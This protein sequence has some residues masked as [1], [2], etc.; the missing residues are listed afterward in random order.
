MYPVTFLLESDLLGKGTEV[1]YI[2]IPEGIS[3]SSSGFVFDFSANFDFS[4]LDK[5]NE[6]E[7]SLYPTIAIES[8]DEFGMVTIGFSDD[9]IVIDDLDEL[10]EKELLLD[11]ELK[12]NLELIVPIV[13]TQVAAQVAF[14]WTAVSFTERQLKIQLFFE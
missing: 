12:L 2:V 13:E 9:L 14:T 1:I 7:L 5:N 4:Q 3:Q 8:I 11:G 6:E 10:T